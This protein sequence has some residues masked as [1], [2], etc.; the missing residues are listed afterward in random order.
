MKA[1]IYGVT[2]Q[3]G[4][5]LAQLLLKKGYEVYGSSR[6]AELSTFANLEKLGIRKDVKTL[7]V[8]A[9]DFRSTHSSLIKVQP[10]E[11]YNLGGQSS[12]GLSFDQPVETFESIATAN[13]N[14][15]EAIRIY[16]R[17][18]KLYNAGSSECFGNTQAPVDENAP[19]NPRSP[20]AVAKSATFWQIKNYR[21]AYNIFAC[22]G[23]LFNHESPFRPSRF[24]TKKIISTALRIQNGS[25]EKLIVGNIDIKRD[26]GWAPEYVEAMWKMLQ[27]PKPDDFIIATGETN[28]LQDFIEVTFSTLNLDWKE[29]VEINKNFYRPTD[30]MESRGNPE[31]ALKQL[32]WK[33]SKKM[34]DVISSLIEFE[35]SS[36][37]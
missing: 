37:S 20:Y 11:I 2:G 16:G 24:V 21:E 31:K 10:D 36:H 19:F 25:K 14:L 17:E 29:H 27:Q 34:K 9:N 7:S 3:D 22:S 13:L 33:A 32:S 5:Y 8:N 1:L 6:D 15:L 26:W 23:I 18:V 30:I 28:S 35:R 12:V 4:S